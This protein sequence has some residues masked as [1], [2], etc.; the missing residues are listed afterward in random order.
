[1][2]LLKKTLEILKKNNKT[3]DDIEY[4]TIINEYDSEKNGL[5]L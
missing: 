5:I 3:F 4:I 2:N 1:M